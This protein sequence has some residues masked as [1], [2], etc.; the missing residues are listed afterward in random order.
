[1]SA[2][3]ARSHC[4]WRQVLL[5][6]F[7]RWRWT[8]LELPPRYFS[9]RVR[10]NPLSW[11][12]S[13]RNTLSQPYDLLIATSMVDLATLRGLV[14]PLAA[15]PSLYYFHENQ[16][17]YPQQAQAHSLLEA[18]MVNLYG[19]LAADRLAFNSR[20]NRDT[21]LTGVEELLSRLP[22]QVPGGVVDSLRE[23][24]SLLPVPLLPQASAV[25]D[26]PGQ[27]GELP[28]RP[29]RILWSARLEHDKGGEGLQRILR[30]LERES[31]DY[32]LAITG[33]QFRNIPAEFAQVESEFR[34]RLVHFG[35]IES[36]SGYQRLQRGA[37]VILS[38]ALHEFQG[39]AVLQ[40][41]R[42]GCLPAVP[43]RL[44]YPDIFPAKFRYAS[45][46][47]D[48]AQ[49]ADAAVKLL[50]Q[51]HRDL[52]SG[53]V[54]APSVESFSV[55]AMEPGYRELLEELAAAGT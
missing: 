32:E 52:C 11:S 37:D 29:L 44:C 27:P 12:L 54:S 55:S 39:L 34:H 24:T 8:V 15:V 48:A 31:I 2:Y 4:Y 13:E 26:W 21:F 43:D 45:R 49:E 7:P 6:M 40:A 22:D 28:H 50:L 18:Q 47:R 51:C 23:K 53:A 42:A 38:T 41:V 30:Q 20:Y 14:P 36:G 25:A 5:A 35:Y 33:Q 10:G 19:A 9:W 17:A 3:A 46:S 1:L 16:F